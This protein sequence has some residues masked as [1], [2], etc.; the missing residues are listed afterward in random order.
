MNR[1]NLGPFGFSNRFSD[2]ICRSAAA[3]LFNLAELAEPAEMVFA[4]ER[5]EWKAL[6]EKLS[7]DV[8]FHLTGGSGISAVEA[9]GADAD[10]Y[11]L[12][13]VRMGKASE[14]ESLP[15][16]VYIINQKKIMKR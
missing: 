15:K 13:G 16:G 12:N 4:L 6:A 3:L 10:V 8:I 2:V 1:E 5:G 11:N 7:Y 9:V 14:L